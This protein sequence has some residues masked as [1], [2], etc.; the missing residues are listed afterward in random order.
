MAKAKKRKAS[1]SPSAHQSAQF[2]RATPNQSIRGKMKKL[3]NKPR[4]PQHDSYHNEPT[5]HE[6]TSTHVE[7]LPRKVRPK[8]HSESTYIDGRVYVPTLDEFNADTSKRGSMLDEV[9]YLPVEDLASLLCGSRI[10]LMIRHSVVGVNILD[11]CRELKHRHS[12]LDL[13]V[14]ANNLLVRRHSARLLL[15]QDCT[16][17]F[18]APAGIGFYFELVLKFIFSIFHWDLNERRRFCRHL[19]QRLA[20]ARLGMPLVDDSFYKINLCNFTSLDPSDVQ[21]A[22]G[23][24]SEEVTTLLECLFANAMRFFVLYCVHSLRNQVIAKFSKSGEAFFRLKIL[25]STSVSSPSTV[26]NEMNSYGLHFRFCISDEVA[27]LPAPQITR[28]LLGEGLF[29]RLQLE[30][31]VFIAQM[32]EYA[33]FLKFSQSRNRYGNYLYSLKAKRIKGF[34]RIP[35]IRIYALKVLGT[36]FDWM[37]SN[38]KLKLVKILCNSILNWN[39]RGQLFIESDF[40]C[41]SFDDYYVLRRFA[42]GRDSQH[43]L[44]IKLLKEIS[45]RFDHFFLV[46]VI[47]ALREHTTIHKTADGTIRFLFKE[48]FAED[49][50]EP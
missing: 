2:H 31:P 35:V 43:W 10:F 16:D 32:N 28:L 45:R 20:E 24:P 40:D 39:S 26:D 12:L 41:D 3:T 46:Y 6:S 42:E 15:F 11:L 4:T 14:V 18:L 37:L 50:F 33:D 22:T 30:S 7:V 47:H 38:K 34:V 1:E 9:S 25:D 17:E 27:H 48:D 36:S 5:F 49:A 44:P 23:L 29:S 19:A 8:E 13:S 21:Q